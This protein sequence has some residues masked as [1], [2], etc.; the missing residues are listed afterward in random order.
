MSN[1]SVS[2]L[3][4]ITPFH[5]QIRIMSRRRLSTALSYPIYSSHSK[6]CEFETLQ[7]P[8][9]MPQIPASH[10]NSA[11]THC[12]NY[13]AQRIHSKRHQNTLAYRVTR[14][15]QKIQYYHFR[16][17][18][19]H[20]ALSMSIVS[21]KK[22]KTSRWSSGLAKP[23]RATLYTK[24]SYLVQCC[25]RVSKVRGYLILDMSYECLDLVA[26]WFP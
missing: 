17:L 14:S 1:L 21:T 2:S 22:E 15:I 19:L 6:P 3:T 5:L 13:P 8:S 26:S 9:C 18:L 11:S 4:P 16:P 20:C 10:K 23:K 24:S 25:F 12:P 7:T